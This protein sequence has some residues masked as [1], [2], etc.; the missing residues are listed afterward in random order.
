MPKW[1]APPITLRYNGIFDFDGMY[2]AVMDW[3]KN[4]GYKWMEKEWKHKVPSPKGA[5]QEI[6]WIIEKKVTDYVFH[7]I[8]FTIHTWEMQDVEVESNGKKKTLTTARLYIIINGTLEGDWQRRFT[9]KFGKMLGDWY[10]QFVAKKDFEG[11]QG[12]VLWYRMWDLHAILK[13]YFDMQSKRYAYK[14]YLGEG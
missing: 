10:Y 7:K 4:Y 13:T 1:E 11:G 9:G 8:E 6:G 5:E 3:A 14:G 2:A 12:D